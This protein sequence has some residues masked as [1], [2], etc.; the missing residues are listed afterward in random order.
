MDSKLSQDT[1]LSLDQPS[2]TQQELASQ[3][4]NPEETRQLAT[5]QLYDSPLSPSK[6]SRF[7]PV[8]RR[9]QSSLLQRRGVQVGISVNLRPQKGSKTIIKS[10]SNFFVGS[11]NTPARGLVGVDSRDYLCL[12]AY[13]PHVLEHNGLN[14]FRKTLK[15]LRKYNPALESPQ[16]QPLKSKHN[17]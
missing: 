5:I 8:H 10:K 17:Q 1:R 6:V 9:M 12:L 13:R 15:K 11:P 3:H 4:S 7:S 14:L 16:F 2:L